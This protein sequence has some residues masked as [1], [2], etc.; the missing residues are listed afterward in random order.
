MNATTLPTTAT[1]SLQQE[2]WTIL[3]I[4]ETASTNTLAGSLP[5]WSAVRA[6]VQT[7]GRGRTGR[8]WI[9]DQGGL[10][11]SAVVPCPGERARWS[12]LPLAAGWSVASALTD[13][14]AHGLRLR[15]PNDILVG[16]RKLAGVLVERFRDDTAV[17]GVGLNVFNH[18]EV[19]DPTLAGETARLA[20]LA[21]GSYD[22]ESLGRTVLRAIRRV[23]RTLTTD[24]FRSISEQL[25]L[26]WSAPRRVE[27]T[28]TGRASRFEG[29]FQGID[30]QGRL[31][32]V[33][34]RDALQVYEP[35]EVALLREI[36]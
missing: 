33:T 22:L 6:A 13:L 3:H 21:H 31:R 11:L 4:E 16:H 14:G 24:G 18:P 35:S 25:N 12:I 15:W 7:G 2:G 9:S 30:Q 34:S 10:W 32:L 8:A 19:A 29:H 26:G 20:D 1:G 5:A 27:V 28:L 17:I 36:D 23:H